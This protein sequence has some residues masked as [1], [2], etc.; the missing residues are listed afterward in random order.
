[1]AIAASRRKVDRSRQRANAAGDIAV[2]SEIIRRS[3]FRK[4]P[5]RD[6]QTLSWRQQQAIKISIALSQKQTWLM[7]P[8]SDTRDMVFN[9]ITRALI[10]LVSGAW[11][12]LELIQEFKNEGD[13]IEPR[14]RVI[15][16]VLDTT[17]TLSIA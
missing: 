17:R 1:V 11:D 2:A 9:S 3:L 10:A 8:K 7:T 13:D 6:G 12:D 15:R 4:F 14:H 5:A 16:I